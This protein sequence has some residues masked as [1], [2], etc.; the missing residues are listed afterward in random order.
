MGKAVQF[1]VAAE[2]IRDM[3]DDENDMGDALVTL[4]VHAGVAAADAI[5]C[6]ALGEHAQ[7]MTM[8]RPST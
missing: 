1:L 5:C 7:G 6:Q 2:T 4:C 8:P 3:A